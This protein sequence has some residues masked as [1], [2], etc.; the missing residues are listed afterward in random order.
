[1]LEGRTSGGLTLPAL[2]VQDIEARLHEREPSRHCG[3]Q[4]AGDRGC[5]RELTAPLP[6]GL[7]PA[8]Q[9]DEALTYL[10]Q[11]TGQHRPPL[12]QRRRPHLE[13]GAERRHGGEALVQSSAGRL[14]GTGPLRSGHLVRLQS[15]QQGLE[16]GDPASL[17]PYPLVLALHVGLH[18]EP[19]GEHRAALVLQVPERRCQ[20]D[21]SGGEDVSPGDQAGL[22]GIGASRLGKGRPEPL[23]GGG[24]HRAGLLGAHGPRRAPPW[25]ARWRDRPATRPPRNGLPRRS[26]PPRPAGAGPAPAPAPNGRRPPPG[27]GSCRGGHPCPPWLAFPRW[28]GARARGGH[29]TRGDAGRRPASL[30]RPP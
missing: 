5:G 27:R 7:L 4:P 12:L 14:A 16:L 28:R 25:W 13:V 8:D 24:R 23:F 26:P 6:C 11:T 29:V 9:G 1:M 3:R 18:A 21:E 17:G 30:W 19:L 10:G 2:L 15:R 20:L 22:S